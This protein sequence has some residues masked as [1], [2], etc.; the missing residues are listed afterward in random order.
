MLLNHLGQQCLVQAGRP[1]TQD[2]FKRKLVVVVGTLAAAALEFD[3]SQ[4][5]ATSFE[6]D[7]FEVDPFEVATAFEV[8]TAV[9][10]PTPLQIV[11][12]AAYTLAAGRLA[13]EDIVKT[14]AAT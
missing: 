3:R 10:R 11:H 9:F 13:S 7:P 8:T 2:S 1:S 5:A 12:L 4:E 14:T 6:V